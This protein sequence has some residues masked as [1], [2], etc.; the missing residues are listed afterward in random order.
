MASFDFKIGAFQQT[1]V[2]VYYILNG[3]NLLSLIKVICWWVLT[4]A[5]YPFSVYNL[6]TFGIEHV[7]LLNWYQ[8][9][10]PDLMNYNQC[11]VT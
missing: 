5:N 6:L 4:H 11:L 2:K 8:I 1:V 10:F 7:L 3:Q 9:I